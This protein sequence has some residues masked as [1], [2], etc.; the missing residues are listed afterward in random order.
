MITIFTAKDLSSYFRDKPIE[1][2]AS[3]IDILEWGK[4][5]TQSDFAIYS[6]G[7]FFFVIKSNYGVSTRKVLPISS[8]SEM[9]R[10]E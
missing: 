2:L 3:D 6:N 9:L 1:E 10:Y 7:T 5:L 8:L 4:T